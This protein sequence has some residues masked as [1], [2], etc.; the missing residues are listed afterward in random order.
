MQ[1]I[2]DKH[3]IE[4]E[5]IIKTGNGVPI[6]LDVE[7]VI[8]FRGRDKLAVSMLMY[9]RQLC[10]EDGCNDFQLATMDNMI[11]KFVA[12]AKTSPTMKQ[13]GITRGK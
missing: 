11:G 4:G 7:P 1:R 10:I 8:L 3:H 9:Y 2:D 12:F 5:R 13:P 6:D